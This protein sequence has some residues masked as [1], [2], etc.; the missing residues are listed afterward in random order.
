MAGTC[1]AWFFAKSRRRFTRQMMPGRAKRH[2]LEYYWHGTL[3]LYAALD[4]RDRPRAWKTRSR[5]TS[6]DFVAFLKE[7]CPCARPN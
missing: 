4:T 3:S 1:A 2:G 6:R 5:H 7:V